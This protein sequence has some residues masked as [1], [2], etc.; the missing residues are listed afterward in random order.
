MTNFTSLAGRDFFTSCIEPVGI[1]YCRY[2]RA[3]LNY[4]SLLTVEI[5]LETRFIFVNVGIRFFG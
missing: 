3:N 2:V 4:L 1:L 5:S